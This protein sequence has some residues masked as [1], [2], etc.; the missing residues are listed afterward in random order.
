MVILFAE[1]LTF[2]VNNYNFCHLNNLKYNL[3]LI[4]LHHV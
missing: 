3:V 4:N 1:V 2:I